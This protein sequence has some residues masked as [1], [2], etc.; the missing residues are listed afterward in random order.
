MQQ[1]R[2][3]AKAIENDVSCAEQTSETRKFEGQEENPSR[4]TLPSRSSKTLAWIVVSLLA[5]IVLSYGA[6]LSVVGITDG[7]RA[8]PSVNGG[9]I[10][11][12]TAKNTEVE[13]LDVKLE[14]FKSP[15]GETFQEVLT[16]WKNTGNTT[17]RVVD[18][19]IKPLAV[20]GLVRDTFHYT[21]YADFD[22][23]PGVAPGTTYV[24][25]PGR[26]FKLPGFEGMPGYVPAS[27]VEIIITKVA[28][29]SGM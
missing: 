22:D 23:Y 1:L 4:T 10:P 16:A 29:K 5:F 28:E 14:P 21:L 6:L 3:E 2:K 25:P 15:S 17:V 26:G 7:P 8:V 27:S 24:T 20:G 18:A 12:S 11:S 9:P 19:R 13:L